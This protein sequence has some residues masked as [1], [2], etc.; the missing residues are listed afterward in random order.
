[1]WCCWAVLVWTAL[2]CAAAGCC[3]LGALYCSALLLRSAASA[4]LLCPGR[5][6]RVPRMAGGS[7]LVAASHASLP[8]PLSVWF[9]H[10][11]ARRITLFCGAL[12]S[13]STPARPK[14]SWPCSL[15]PQRQQQRLPSRATLRHPLASAM[16]Q[17][18]RRQR[19][20]AH[21][22]C[23]QGACV[24]TC[25]PGS[26]YRASR[27]AYACLLTSSFLMRTD[28]CLRLPPDPLLQYKAFVPAPLHTHSAM[29]CPA[30]TSQTAYPYSYRQ[31]PLCATHRPAH[32]LQTFSL[33][34]GTRKTGEW[35]GKGGAI[36][37]QGGD[38]GRCRK[39]CG[40]WCK[41]GRA[42]KG[43]AE[44]WGSKWENQQQGSTSSSSSD[45]SRRVQLPRQRPAPS[46]TRPLQ[47]SLVVY[48]I[49]PA[50]STS[51]ML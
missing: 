34:N 22:Q 31:P 51:I 20:Q 28:S 2:H 43:V 35:M 46:P 17:Q 50:D 41:E 3:C 47:R 48:R 24:A 12:S 36:D 9:R 11:T 27:W 40:L 23:L 16:A 44:R 39:Q 8:A 7:A 30:T 14:P 18:Q 29:P 33:I 13:C 38:V 37:S 21:R 32:L 1:M 42:S 49:A 15:R 5:W 10:C 25:W 26:A 4:V 19:P 6:C 45:T